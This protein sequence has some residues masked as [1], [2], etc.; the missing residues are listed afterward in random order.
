M[1]SLEFALTGLA[2]GALPDLRDDWPTAIRAAALF[3]TAAIE[4]TSGEN[5]LEALERYLAA[6]RGVLGPFGYVSVHGPGGAPR[7]G[8]WAD[9]T[10]RLGA[11]PAAVSTIVVHADAMTD[12]A[13]AAL[14]PLG[15]RIAVENMDPTR[16]SGQTVSDMRAV[17]AALPEARMVLDVAHAHQSDSSGQLTRDLAG[18]FEGRIAHLHCS[19]L[20]NGREHWPPTAADA[21]WLARDIAACPPV[22]RLWEQL[23]TFAA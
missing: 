11:L 10:A 23:P 3:S 14:R 13:C 21:Q 5:R 19:A 20:R 12:E 7:H 22:P 4:L 16:P 2:T 15:T 9:M 8:S 17:F 18:A 6:D 1:T